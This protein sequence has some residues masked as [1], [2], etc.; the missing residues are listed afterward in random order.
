MSRIRAQIA[1]IV[2]GDEH[3]T[4]LLDTL[5]SQQYEFQCPS[6]VYAGPGHQSRHDCEE[7][8]PHPIEGDHSDSMYWWEGTAV[9]TDAEGRNGTYKRLMFNPRHHGGDCC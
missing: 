9:M 6:F 3:L 4:D 8:S 7:R 2:G 1:E 5:V